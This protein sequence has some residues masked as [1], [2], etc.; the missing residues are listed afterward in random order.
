MPQIVFMKPDGEE[1][2]VTEEIKDSKTA[3]DLEKVLKNA[4]TKK[5]E[6]NEPNN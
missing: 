5:E 4:L 3:K 2:D 6:S 1:V